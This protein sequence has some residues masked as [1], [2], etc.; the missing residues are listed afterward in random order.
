M[1]SYPLL[2]GAGT[3]RTYESAKMDESG[4][5]EMGSGRAWT[6]L[7]IALQGT[8]QLSHLHLHTSLN[9]LFHTSVDA[10]DSSSPSHLIA[11][12]AYSLP[13]LTDPSLSAEG[14]KVIRTEPLAFVFKVGWVDGDVLPGMVGRPITGVRDHGVG[15]TLLSFFALAASA[16]LGAM[17]MMIWERR[18]GGAIMNGLPP[19]GVRGIGMNGHSGYGGH[20]GYRGYG[21]YGVGKR[22]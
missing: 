1:P 12:T 16:G 20:S 4:V 7:T 11:S 13:N 18:R 14:T 19:I 8:L 3:V 15:F 10:R 6:P 21:G 5:V 2:Q 17:V 9:V 22:D